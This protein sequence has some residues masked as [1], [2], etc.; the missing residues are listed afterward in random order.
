MRQPP[1]LNVT[2]DE[3]PRGGMQDMSA[4]PGR[5]GER[6]RHTVLKLVAEAVGA[7]RDRA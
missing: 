7:A 4:G 5:L 3:L 6:Q 2:L 1:V